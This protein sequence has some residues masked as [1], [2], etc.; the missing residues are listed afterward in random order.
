MKLETGPIQAQSGLIPNFF[1]S[2]ESSSF[3]SSTSYSPDCS[4][5]LLLLAPFFF[6]IRSASLYFF[7][8][9]NW[10]HIFVEDYFKTT[11]G[12]STSSSPEY[13][14]ISSMEMMVLYRY[15]YIQVLNMTN[16]CRL[17]PESPYRFW[18]MFDF[19]FD[20]SVVVIDLRVLGWQWRA[21]SYVR[22]ETSWHWL[23]QLQVW[24]YQQS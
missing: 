5:T 14:E 12:S 20:S 10:Y 13:F 21:F 9:I 23:P 6:M 7:L 17:F 16:V 1:W 8:Y 18:P 22:E 15:L 2:V 11:P 3:D 24:P 19:V 4:V